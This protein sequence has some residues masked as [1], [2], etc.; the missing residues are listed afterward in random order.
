MG[1]A[2]ISPP[3]GRYEKITEEMD[4]RMRPDQLRVLVL[5]DDD[6]VWRER[7]RKRL[8]SEGMMCDAVRDLGQFTALLQREDYD[9]AS[10]DWK[11][12]RIREEGADE[13]GGNVLAQLKEKNP[14][15]GRVVFSAYMGN[16]HDKKEAF[17]LGAD[18]VVEKHAISED[19]EYVKAVLNAA[20]LKF[21]RRVFRRLNPDDPR[22]VELSNKLSDEQEQ[23]LYSQALRVLIASYLEGEE[24]GDLMNELERRG[25]VS[26][27][28]SP[29]YLNLPFFGKLAKLLSYVRVTPT[30]LAR[31]L[32]VEVETADALLR[33]TNDP[34]ISD[35]K[36]QG[37]Y[38]LASILEFVLRLSDDKPT[39]MSGFWQAQHLY[40]ESR[41]IPPWDELGLGNYLASN[42]TK[43]LEKAVRWIRSY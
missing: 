28:D 4:L 9:V 39:L 17:F 31:I 13:Y 16:E 21:F 2:A 43:G 41:N 34:Q 6:K 24:D 32:E 20:R 8:V 26:R 10:I 3:D 12:E 5:E 35:L 23:E 37:A 19:D 15:M 11:L 27:F 1:A 7:I 33:G 22:E 25:I 14:A 40:A 30:E 42:G 38:W 36:R 29:S 18:C